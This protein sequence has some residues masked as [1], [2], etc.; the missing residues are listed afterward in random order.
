MKFNRPYVLALRSEGPVAARLLEDVV[1]ANYE[2]FR[3]F[4]TQQ[5]LLPSKNPERRQNEKLNG[6]VVGSNGNAPKMNGYPPQ[7]EH[8]TPA[9]GSIPSFNPPGPAASITGSVRPRPALAKKGKKAAYPAGTLMA[10]WA[11]ARAN[12]ASSPCEALEAADIVRSVAE[13]LPALP[14]T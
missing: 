10:I 1:S 3:Q 11:E 8:Q 12:G 13:F 2:D 14:A 5:L 4:A 7:S 6:K 9:G